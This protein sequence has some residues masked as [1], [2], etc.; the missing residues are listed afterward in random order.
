ML[1]T[2][3]LGGLCPRCLLFQAAL[4]TGDGD[5]SASRPLPPEVEVV[6]AAFPQLEV[7]ELIGQG[8]MGAVYKARQKSLDRFVAIKLLM[9]KSVGQLDF[10]ARFAREAKALAELNHPNIVT[11]HDFGQAGG[12]Y[13]LLMEYVDGVNLRQAMD[14][15]RMLSAQ[16][17]SIIPPVCEAL[18]FAHSRGIVH[19]DIKPENL[20]ID[21]RGHVKI[22]DFGIARIVRLPADDVALDNGESTEEQN[23]SLQ[24]TGNFVLGTPNY[25][26]PEQTQNPE[27]VDQRADV[28]SLGVVLYEMLTGELPRGSIEMPS[29]KVQID[30]RLDEIVLKALDHNPEL[31]WPTTAAFKAQ[32]EKLSATGVRNASLPMRA[33]ETSAHWGITFAATSTILFMSLALF[34]IVF[35]WSAGLGRFFAAG[36]L[37]CMPMA[38][39]GAFLTLAWNNSL[40]GQARALGIARQYRPLLW[41][42]WVG[43]VLF[44]PIIGLAIS[45]LDAVCSIQGW[46]PL[47]DEWIVTCTAWFGTVAMPVSAWWLY[48]T[49]SEAKT[50]SI[51]SKHFFMQRQAWMDMGIIAILLA[52]MLPNLGFGLHFAKESRQAQTQSMEMINLQH[53]LDAQLAEQE[54]LKDASSGN[55]NDE[56]KAVE[57]KIDKLTRELNIESKK[58]AIVSLGTLLACFV[59][60]ALLGIISAVIL[61]CNLIEHRAIRIGLTL[62]I[63]ACVIV[64]GA[65]GLVLVIEKLITGLVVSIFIVVFGAM[66]LALL[67]YARLKVVIGDSTQPIAPIEVYKTSAAMR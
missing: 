10:E 64:F 51:P 31:R 48:R 3:A 67:V 55:R 6:Q 11:I 23:S 62:F 35:L 37:L 56:L 34:M 57:A 42:A 9:R 28:Y 29:R 46:N 20:L 18:T 22:A 53:Q 47:F 50:E 61:I 38:V 19:R 32:L 14:A 39:L 58:T 49:A 33:P 65:I 40:A 54:K 59:M 30:V 25:M 17:L 41:I 13:F 7:I 66:V 24:L 4:D 12:F 44:V 15:G 27:A 52:I 16:A 43:A 21:K 2:E 60:G 26:A 1:P 36:V 8:G 5:A 63:S 45:L